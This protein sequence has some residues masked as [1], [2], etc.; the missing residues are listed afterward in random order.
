MQVGPLYPGEFKAVMQAA[1][2]L[3]QKV[4]AA[5]QAESQ[6]VAAATTAPTGGGGGGGTA[7]VAPKI[8]LKMDFSAFG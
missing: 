2:T 6:T 4:G 7:M 5:I 3:A 1:P 8:Q